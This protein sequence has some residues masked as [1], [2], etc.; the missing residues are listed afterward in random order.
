M[1][2]KRILTLLT[3]LCLCWPIKAQIN[4]LSASKLNSF[5]F[6]PVNKH[7]LEFEPGFSYAI[8]RNYWDN[9]GRSVQSFSGNDSLLAESGLRYRFTYGLTDRLEMGVTVTGDMEMSYWGIKYKIWETEKTGIAAIGGLNYPFGTGVRDSKRDEDV[10]HAGLGSV[11]TWMPAENFSVDA[12][13][14]GSLG[15]QHHE[16]ALKNYYAAGADAGYYLCNGR[17]QLAA[18]LGFQH[19]DFGSYKQSLLTFYPG[20]T[21]ETGKDFIITLIHSVDLA[22]KN[23][24]QQRVTDVSFTFTLH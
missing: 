11:I 3:I 12:F 16:G 7:E 6:D 13:L 4:G 2:L 8:S 14:Q 15:I 10:P 9:E 18:A 17:L 19:Y 22:G 5:C 20:V 24:Y 23:C 21:I 1:D